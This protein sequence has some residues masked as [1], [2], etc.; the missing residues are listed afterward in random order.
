MYRENN[1]YLLYLTDNK[2][3]IVFIIGKCAKFWT[4]QRDSHLMNAKKYFIYLKG[5]R[6]LVLFYPSGDNFDL[7][8]YADVDY[9]GYRVDRK[10]TFRMANFFGSC[11]FSWGSKSKILLLSLLLKLNMQ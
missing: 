10:S 11:L 3:Y 1:G 6:D 5:I 9:V 7:I 4:C 8:G 2:P